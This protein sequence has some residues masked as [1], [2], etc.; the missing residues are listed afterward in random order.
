MDLVID[1]HTTEGCVTCHPTPGSQLREFNSFHSSIACTFCHYSH[2]F[3]P[4]C[5][6]CHKPHIKEGTKESCSL[7]HQAHMPLVV[8]YGE[9][10]TVATAC[11]GCHDAVDKLLQAS[12][13]KHSSLACT[14]CHQDKHQTIPACTDCHDIPHPPAMLERFPICGQCHNIAHD[15]HL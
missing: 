10:E 4:A 13:T 8:G 2:G 3:V 1:S 12:E 14:F 6:D 11:A 15:L 9:E 7:C 5:T